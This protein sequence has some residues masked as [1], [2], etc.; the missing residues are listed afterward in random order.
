MSS[1][2]TNQTPHPSTP[3]TYDPHIIPAETAARKDREGDSYKHIPENPANVDSIDTTGGYT[4][5]KE[6]I[7]NNYASE[8]EMYSETVGDLQEVN[9]NLSTRNKYTIIDT[10]ASPVDAERTVLKMKE[11][12]LDSHKISIIGK[13]YQDTEYVHGDLNWR[14]ID[15]AGGLVVVLE[16]LGISPEEALQHDAVINAGKFVVLVTGTDEDMHQA[17]QILHDIGHRLNQATAA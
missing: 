13:D 1:D 8:P 2:T 5:D 3:D 7:V 11:A 16:K 6:G 14:D 15:Q 12:G 10:F 9:N 17:Y 4:V